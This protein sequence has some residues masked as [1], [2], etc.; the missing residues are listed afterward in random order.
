MIRLECLKKGSSLKHSIKLFVGKTVVGD[1]PGIVRS[2]LYRPE[3]FGKPMGLL[4]NAVV[5]GPSEWTMGERELFSAYVSAKNRCQFCVGAHS[6][7]ADRALGK[8]VAGQVVED[9]ERAP[10]SA[11]AR[12]MLA[13][14]EKLTVTPDQVGGEDIARL[15]DDGISDA[16]IVDG[17]YICMLFAIFNRIVFATGVEP[18]TPEQ[19]N[20]LSFALVKMGY[21]L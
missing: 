15:R 17:I 9:I 19:A 13:F 11:R 5:R 2:L 1:V 6:A 18:M 4:H 10:V 8:P 12:A 21:D 16:S 20:R 3:F 14:L 7:V